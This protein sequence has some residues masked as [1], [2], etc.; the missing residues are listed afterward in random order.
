M[1]S[2]RMIEVTLLNKIK[3]LE[4]QRGAN[5]SKL[6]NTH[7][8]DLNY[9]THYNATSPIGKHMEMVRKTGGFETKKKEFKVH[10]R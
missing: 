10:K 1:D 4:H 2:M 9:T 6:S 3:I 5:Y 7:A 8:V